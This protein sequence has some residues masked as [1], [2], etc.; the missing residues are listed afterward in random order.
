M[1]DGSERTQRTPTFNTLTR[2]RA[3]RHP[4]QDGSAYNVLNEFVAPHIESF[5]ALFDDSGLSPGDGDGKGILSLALKDIGERVVFDGNGNEISE[6]ETYDWG[7]RMRSESKFIVRSNLMMHS[8]H[9]LVWIEKVTIARPMVPEKDIRALERRVFPSEVSLA[10]ISP[11][12]HLPCSRFGSL[13]RYLYDP[14]TATSIVTRTF[15]VLPWADDPQ[16]MLD[17]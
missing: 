3:F 7:N 14:L 4:T 1:P 17:R 12:C 13:S 11:T 2:E 10:R 8:A 16:T 6:N 15:D 5:N 9:C